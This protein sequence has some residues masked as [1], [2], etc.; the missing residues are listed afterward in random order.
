MSQQIGY[1]RVSTAEQNLN[2][3]KDELKK[4]GCEKF[5]EDK[6]SGALSKSERPGLKVAIEYARAG[7]TLVVWKLD[8]LGRSISDLIKIITELNQKGVSFKTLTGHS[9]DTS[10]A[11]GKLIFHIFAALAE[12]EKE[13]IKE[14]TNAGLKSARAR[15]FIGGR[16]SIITPEK[17]EWQSFY[18]LTQ[19]IKLQI[20]SKL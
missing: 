10:N 19:R 7:D 5:F 17:S 2:L 13:L 8:R 1:I 15:G 16:P 4:I 20:F 9:I 3:Q 18:M 12:F 14:R 11:S 6:I